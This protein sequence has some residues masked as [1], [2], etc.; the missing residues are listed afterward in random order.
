[1]GSKVS[2]YW[3]YI[4][5][6]RSDGIIQGEENSK[7]VYIEHNNTNSK[8]DSVKMKRYGRV[9]TDS[10]GNIMFYPTTPLNDTPLNDNGSLTFLDKVYRRS[11]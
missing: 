6:H 7:L 11:R 2:E 1:M 9:V 5:N 8:H 4:N 3:I 10:N